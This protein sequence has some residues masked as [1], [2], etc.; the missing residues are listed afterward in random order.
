MKSELK[1]PTL[2][3]DTYAHVGIKKTDE[4]LEVFKQKVE[5]YFSILNEVI[6]ADFDKLTDRELYGLLT[7]V[8]DIYLE[9]ADYLSMLSKYNHTKYV[10]SHKIAT[11]L[12]LCDSDSDDDITPP[13]YQVYYTIATSSGFKFKYNKHYT[14][15]EL[16]KLIA[17]KKIIILEQELAIISNDSSFD[18]D[19]YENLPNLNVSI[20]NRSSNMSSFVFEHFELFGELLRKKMLKRIVLKDM[21]DFA[22]ILSKQ[23]QTIFTDRNSPDYLF[24]ELATMCY[25]WFIANE[26]KEYRTIRKELK[27][28]KK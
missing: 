14:K 21:R 23:L 28:T 13:I 27:P 18:E 16:K 10:V 9:E 6:E 1:K 8:Y 4:N 19:E 5:S 12:V 25:D 22:N 20:R 11:T 24:S 17:E 15:E 2:V 3:E 26:E 7:K